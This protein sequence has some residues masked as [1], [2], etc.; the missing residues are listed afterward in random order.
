MHVPSLKFL[1][2]G[3]LLCSG[4]ALRLAAQT[5]PDASVALAAGSV[6]TLNP[7][8]PTVFVAGDSTSAAGGAGPIQGWGVPFAAYFDAAKVNV[9][10][11]S[12]GGRSSRTFITDGSWEQVI[13]KVKAGDYVLLQLGINDIGAINDEPPGPLRARGTIPG[14]GEDT[15]EIDNALTKKHEVV[16]TYGWYMRKMISDTQAKGA[17]PILLS[18][19][20][21]NAWKDGKVE[22]VFGGYSEW[23]RQLAVAGGVAFIDVSNLVADHFEKTGAEEMAKFY[24]PDRTH[25]NKDGADFNAVTVVSGLK[26]LRG[27]P[28]GQYLSPKGTAVAAAPAERVVQPAN[29]NAALS[30]GAH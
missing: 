28:F 11:G 6:P 5:A 17:T 3:L 18:L 10:N 12:R 19:T 2:T 25:T 8:L 9:Y 22:R 23:S 1:F 24:Q 7:Q 4:L 14:I 29:S 20:I 30:P 13:G 15:K 21:R 26:A 27:V 16:H